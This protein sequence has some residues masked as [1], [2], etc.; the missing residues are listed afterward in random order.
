MVLKWHLAIVETTGTKSTWVVV[1]NHISSCSH[2]K[3][4]EGMCVH[5]CRLTLLSP[6]VDTS[7]Q[8]RTTLSWESHRTDCGHVFNCHF[9]LF[10]VCA[11]LPWCAS[12]EWVGS[13]LPS[14]RSSGI[15]LHPSESL[16]W[17]LCY[18]LFPAFETGSHYAT[19]SDLEFTMWTWLV[20]KLRGPP[21]SVSLVVALKAWTTYLL[22]IFS[23]LFFISMWRN[24]H[25]KVNTPEY[26]T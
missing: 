1:V 16:P 3:P 23:Q 9:Y 6:T 21:T 22:S 17:P 2:Q 11:Y 18:C 20:S 15:V 12:G 19:I 10:T 24:K 13:L 14:C 5:M 7:P 8:L 4:F 25:M 26:L